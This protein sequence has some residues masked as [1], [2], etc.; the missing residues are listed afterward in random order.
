MKLSP[1]AIQFNTRGAFNSAIE[2]LNHHRIFSARD[3]LPK[4]VNM[5]MIFDLRVMENPLE[6]LKKATSILI[7]FGHFEEG[8]DFQLI[9]Q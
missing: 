2:L 7:E 8:S 9:N 5:Q 6:T 4:Y 3:Y 1:N